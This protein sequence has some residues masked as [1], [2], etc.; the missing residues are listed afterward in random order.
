M[1]SSLSD[2]FTEC[3]ER[4]G[5]TCCDCGTKEDLEI[6]HILP[7]S[8][9]GK[10]IIENLKTVC[11]S[12]HDSNYNDVHYPK[13][14]GVIIPFKERE[15]SRY[16]IDKNRF[17]QILMTFPNE[18]VEEI[19]AFWH[20]EKI[21]NRSEAIRELVVRGLQKYKEGSSEHKG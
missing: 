13:D 17:S 3:F 4:D 6:H 21:K 1:M 12:C 18:M 5:Y 19:E 11:C 20:D 9:G 8:Q 16:G 7:I 14:K 15:K 2:L 10:N